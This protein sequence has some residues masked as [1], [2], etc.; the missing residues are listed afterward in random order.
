MQKVHSFAAVPI[1][2][3]EMKKNKWTYSVGVLAWKREHHWVF[4]QPNTVFYFFLLAALFFKRSMRLPWF[5]NSSARFLLVPV[6]RP[7][8][9]RCF[10]WCRNGELSSGAG[11]LA[12]S[13]CSVSTRSRNTPLFVLLI[14]VIAQPL[15][16][17]LPARPTWWTYSSIVAG[18]SKL[19]TWGRGGSGKEVNILVTNKTEDWLGQQHHSPFNTTCSDAQVRIISQTWNILYRK[20]MEHTGETIGHMRDEDLG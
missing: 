6:F 4:T 13:G 7:V 14:K 18:M 1:T 8:F 9:L 2:S 11:R 17:S 20:S 3:N 16:P 12:P 10:A 15:A 19:I 5:T